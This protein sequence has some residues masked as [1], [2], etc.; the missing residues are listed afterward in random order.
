MDP[1]LVIENVSSSYLFLQSTQNI[2]RVAYLASLLCATDKM[3]DVI[4]IYN[5]VTIQHV[6]VYAFLLSSF[7]FFFLFLG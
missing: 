2:S 1:I 4:Y 7:P 5:D 3:F 6:W